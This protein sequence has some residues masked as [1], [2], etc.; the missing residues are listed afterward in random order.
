MTP[1]KARETTDWRVYV[2]L[3]PRH[4]HPGNDLYETAR[5]ALR[6]GAG[7]LQLRDKESSGLEL[8]GCARD[9]QAICDE[10]G[11][12]FVVNDR[13]DVAL[14][15]DADG[16]HLGP[17]DVPVRD[18]RRLAPDLLIGGSAGSVQRAEDLVEEGVDY[19]G[20]GAV[21]DAGR[22]KPDAS[23]PRGPEAVGA[24]ARTVDIP[25]VGIGGI[26]PD[27]ARAVIEHGADGVAVIRAVVQH[28]DPE[29]AV[30]ELL[31]AIG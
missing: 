13:F 8:V 6:G 17:E 20:C 25:V 27:N 22:S 7:V 23:E 15:A 24:I 19:L 10:F 18:V 26:T 31:E 14:A 11:A 30:E 16:V 9:L 2:I 3:D 4:L 29:Q 28:P 21:Y 1:S 5:A 12:T